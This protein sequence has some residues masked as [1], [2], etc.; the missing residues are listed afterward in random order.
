MGL[1][2][3]TM[4]TV[5]LAAA[6]IFVAACGSSEPAEPKIQE[7]P[8]RWKDGRLLVDVP[9]RVVL[10]GFTEASA[11]KLRAE[12]KPLRVKQAS[13]WYPPPYPVDESSTPLASEW[14]PLPINPAAHFDVRE[15]SP[16][17]E[18][19]FHGA[20]QEAGSTDAGPLFSANR[21]ED[22]LAGAL[23]AEGL[24]DPAAPTVVMVNLPVPHA[25]IYQTSGL[26]PM[27]PLRTFGERES[28]LVL[29][30]SAYA[31]A[32]AG[33]GGYNDP[34]RTSDTETLADFVRDAVQFRLLQGGLYPVSTAACH[35]VTVLVG[36]RLSAADLAGLDPGEVTTAPI[37]AAL[38]QL[39]GVPVYVD[40]KVL[41]LPVDDPALD[42]ASRASSRFTTHDVVRVWL[43]QNWETYHVDHPGCAE[44]LTSIF[45][46]ETVQP[47]A[48]PLD[49]FVNTSTAGGIALADGDPER[50]VAISWF[51]DR[52]IW[53]YDS[54]YCLPQGCPTDDYWPWVD[55]TLVHETGHL[56]GLRHPHDVTYEYGTAGSSRAFSGNWSA[57]SYRIGPA[58][59]EFS[60]VDRNNWLRNRAAFALQEAEAVGRAG[61]PEWNAALAAAGAL[62]WEGVWTVL[63]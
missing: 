25:W 55:Y 52:V 38:R 3:V 26:Y 56:F 2:G 6:T 13:T 9:I 23:A 11:G 62:D 37:E 12:L 16:R 43:D 48:S 49:L 39:T 33:S 54:N 30:P 29:D 51:P 59:V 34:V 24:L 50:R 31:D 41:N 63:K 46:Y 19:A 15:A 10:I 61:S 45:F 21:V 58:F 14:A 27:Q 42:A 40:L 60:A 44:Y 22:A 36:K 28:L 32:F 8:A 4:R 35:A 57:M 20:L 53:G 47:E 1:Q 18:S 17:V 5:L 7:V